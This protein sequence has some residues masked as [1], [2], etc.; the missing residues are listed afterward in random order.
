MD[1]T[2]FTVFLTY[3]TPTVAFEGISKTLKN[4]KSKKLCRID[5]TPIIGANY[6]NICVY[7]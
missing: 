5:I 4:S 1:T 6:W 7:E 2:G 3:L